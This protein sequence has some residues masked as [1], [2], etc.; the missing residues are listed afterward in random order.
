[1]EINVFLWSIYIYVLCYFEFINNIWFIDLLISIVDIFGVRDSFFVIMYDNF[2]FDI[3]IF[4]LFIELMSN[5]LFFVFWSF[6]FVDSLF[7]NFIFS[8]FFI[9]ILSFGLFIDFIDNNLFVD[10]INNV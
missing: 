4:E 10:I 8:L 1:M 2:I 5:D 9:F 6:D 7:D 3:I